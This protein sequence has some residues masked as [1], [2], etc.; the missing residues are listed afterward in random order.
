MCLIYFKF[1]KVFLSV[2]KKRHDYIAAW[3][4]LVLN[5]S[6]YTQPAFCILHLHGYTQVKLLRE[7]WDYICLSNRCILL[8]FFK[9]IDHSPPYGSSLGF[10][11]T[12]IHI[13][14][15]FFFLHIQSIYVLF[16]F[17]LTFHTSSRMF[18]F[19]KLAA[20]VVFSLS[21]FQQWAP[22]M[23]QSE[24]IPKMV[25]CEKEYQQE[26]DCTAVIAEMTASTINL[27]VSWCGGL[28]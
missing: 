26:D 2:R 3:L 20:Q 7:N 19:L 24:V 22:W 23:P 4:F 10:F 1:Y 9:V 13:Q 16:I 27:E 28:T 14:K 18:I 12:C 15:S 25:L 17:F 11:L 8:C 6:Q 5:L 21:S